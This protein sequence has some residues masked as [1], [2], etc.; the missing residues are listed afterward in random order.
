M[1]A[2]FGFHIGPFY[3]SQRLGRTQTQKRAAARARNQRR[4]ARAQQRSAR[5][6]RE[7]HEASEREWNAPE[8][9]AAREAARA[10]HDARTYRAVISECRIDG[11]KGGGFTIE[12]D[13]RPSVGI[14]VEPDTALRFLSLRNGD[15]VQ[16]TLAPDNGGLEEFWHLSRANGAKPRS[17]ANFRRGELSSRRRDENTSPE[18]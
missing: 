14:T 18:G 2:R 12:A 13:D 1:P 6:Q 11:L 9:V 4:S 16:V 10:D 5:D 17:P 8:A 7:Q 15:I 3:F